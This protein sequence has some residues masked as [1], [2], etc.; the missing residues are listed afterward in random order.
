MVSLL[1]RATLM[2]P[3]GKIPAHPAG[4]TPAH[5][6]YVNHPSSKTQFC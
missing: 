2:H 6:G 4:E 3:A 1:A 5:P